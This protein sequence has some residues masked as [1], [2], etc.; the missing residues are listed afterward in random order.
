MKTTKPIILAS[1]SPRRK[2]LLE[3]AGVKF[4]IAESKFKEY[5]NLKLEPHALAQKLSLEKAK[6]VYK[7]FKNSIIIAAD[8]F[9]VYNGTIFGKPKD[10][11][12]AK[13]MLSILSNKTHL[14]ITGFTI[15]NGEKIITKSEETKVS[16]RKISEA[17]IDSYINTKEP[18]DKAGAYAIQGEAKKFIEKIDGDLPNAIG[19]PIHTLLKD[20]KKIAA[21]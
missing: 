15:I 4:K 18:F 11:T 8:T 21:I 14:I 2:E 10:Q 3:K 20:L 9:V 17:E 12:D 6:T 5:F 7:K 1:G 13:R 16:M 19:L